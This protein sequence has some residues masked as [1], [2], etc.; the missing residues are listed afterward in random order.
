MPVMPLDE[1]QPD[2]VAETVPSVATCKQRVPVPP[3]EETMRFVVDA[4]VEVIA[5]VEA[6]GRIEAEV[7]VA[8]R[9]VTNKGEEEVATIF[10]PSKY[11]REFAANDDCP[12]PPLV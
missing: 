11:N 7:P 10:D 8:T 9:R 12:V 2:A 3:A 1:P 4:F 5:V 6:N